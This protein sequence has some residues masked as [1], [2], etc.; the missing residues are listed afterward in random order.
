MP[1][2]K[3]RYVVPKIIKMQ[4]HKQIQPL[5][6][7]YTFVTTLLIFIKVKIESLFNHRQVV[8]LYVNTYNKTT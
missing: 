6:Q 7:Y 4:D 3:F 2:L 8:I 5:G 1:L